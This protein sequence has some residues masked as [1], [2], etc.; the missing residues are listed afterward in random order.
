MRKLFVPIFALLL[1]LAFGAAVMAQSADDASDSFD[2]SVTNPY[3][4]WDGAFAP[5]AFDVIVEPGMDRQYSVTNSF[6]VASTTPFAIE[7]AAAWTSGR[8]KIDV[9]PDNAAIGAEVNI[10]NVFDIQISSRGD[11]DDYST[12]R[13]LST[14][15]AGTKTAREQDNTLAE[16]DDAVQYGVRV[17]LVLVDEPNILPGDYDTSGWDDS[18][19]PGL[20]DRRFDSLPA[21]DYQVDV[22]VT[23]SEDV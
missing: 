2:V 9:N 21:G 18:G 5:D 10:D 12:D 11:T 23:I 20:N 13:D 6:T 3:V 19:G 8:E 15:A 22:T 14:P 7:V 17:T 4:E 16:R 1:A